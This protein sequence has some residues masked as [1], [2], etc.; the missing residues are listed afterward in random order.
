MN[1][2]T[3]WEITPQF[4]QVEP[5]PYFTQ[6]EL[7]KTLDKYDMKRMILYP[8]GNGDQ[9]SMSRSSYRRL[10]SSNQNISLM[11]YFNLEAKIIKENLV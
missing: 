8:L 3:K 5:H 9:A 6:R 7:R 10:I 2:Q 1:K 11:I 4:I